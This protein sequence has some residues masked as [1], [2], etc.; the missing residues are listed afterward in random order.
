[1]KLKVVYFTRTGT[2]K[3]IAE[4]IA[5]ELSCDHI[6]ITDGMNWKGIF[7]FIRGG[8]YASKDKAVDIKLSKEVGDYDELVVVSP[9]W[10]GGT[11]PAIRTFLKNVPLEKV[12]LLITSNGSSAKDRS[13]YKCVKD[14]IRSKGNEDAVISELVK[15]LLA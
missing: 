9:L 11:S 8:Y 12:N 14:I 6:E 7:G 5:S 15:K 10:A 13:G 3:R 1:M 2:S 4:K